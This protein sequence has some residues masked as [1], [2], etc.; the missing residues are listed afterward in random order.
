MV[1]EKVVVDFLTF[2][3]NVDVMKM[4]LLLFKRLLLAFN[5]L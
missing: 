5:L 2:Y 3:E 1:F 4:L